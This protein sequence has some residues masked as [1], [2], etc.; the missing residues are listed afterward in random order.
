MTE[1]TVA[2]FSK[3]F[4]D[5]NHIETVIN[6]CRTTITIQRRRLAGDSLLGEEIA[7]GLQLLQVYFCARHISQK[8]N[9]MKSSKFICGMYPSQHALSTLQAYVSCSPI[10]H[11][12]I[13]SLLHSSQYLSSILSLHIKYLSALVILTLDFATSFCT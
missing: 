7:T 12:R 8:A 2:H 9:T 6:A 1:D 11:N 4:W 3:K 5:S 10:V 13:H